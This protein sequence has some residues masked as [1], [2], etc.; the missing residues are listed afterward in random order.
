M[1]LV[2]YISN[3]TDKATIKSY[4][5]VAPN[6]IHDNFQCWQEVFTIKVKVV[7]QWEIIYYGVIVCKS[8]NAV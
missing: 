2:F 4:A 6:D 7:K 3:V 8:F 1:W 5:E